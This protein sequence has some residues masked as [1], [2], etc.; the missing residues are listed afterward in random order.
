LA[1]VEP[2]IT[3][4]MP[5]NFRFV[6]LIHLALPGARIIHARRDPLATCLSCFEQ[7]FVKDHQSFSYDLAELGRYYRAYQ[8]LMAHWCNVLPAGVMLEVQY[9]DLVRDPEPEARRIVEFCGL[10]WDPRCLAFHQTDRPIHT[11]SVAQVREPIYRSS[12][13]RWQPVR[14]MLGPLLEGLGIEA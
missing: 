9:E 3:D 14:H 2:R 13:G 7:L 11:A 6:G 1:P 10:D 5:A 12:L 8:S 4:K